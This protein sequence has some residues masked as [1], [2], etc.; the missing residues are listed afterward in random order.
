MTSHCSWSPAPSLVWEEDA[1]HDWTKTIT[2]VV[3]GTAL[4]SPS[5]IGHNRANAIVKSYVVHETIIRAESPF[6]E[7]ALSKEWKESQERVVKLPEQYPE[8]FDIYVRWIYSGKLLI[9]RIDLTE[10]SDFVILTSNLSRAYILGDVLQDTDFKDAIIDSYFDIK[11]SAKW[12]PTSG[13]K[14]IF[15]NTSKKSS[16][17]RMLVDWVVTNLN[18]AQLCD[19]RHA[20]YTTVEFYQSVMLR[21]KDKENGNFDGVDEEVE[22]GDNHEQGLQ[23]S[24][25]KTVDVID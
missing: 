15:D 14:F 6:F 23:S 8:A 4:E 2:V 20:T 18:L 22:S 12:I 7:A 5:Q 3:G 19:E 10:I 17:R 21:V 11:K 25:A 24:G 1:K 16:L 13:V 9:S